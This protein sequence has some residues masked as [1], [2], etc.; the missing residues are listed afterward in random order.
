MPLC[1]AATLVAALGFACT[2]A[3]LGDNSAN[4]VL[5]S[6]AMHPV[7]VAAPANLHVHPARVGQWALYRLIDASGM[8]YEYVGITRGKCGVWFEDAWVAG[9]HRTTS[10][11]CYREMPDLDHG[12]ESWLALVRVAV[13][14]YDDELPRVVDLRAGVAPPS[15]L[16][17]QLHRF[18]GNFDGARWRH[19]DLP[20]DDVDVSAG[21]FA[22]AVRVAS[23]RNA[24]TMWFHPEV[25]ITGMV[26][27][28]ARDG[29]ELELAAFGEQ[30]A[31]SAI[32]DVPDSGDDYLTCTQAGIGALS[33]VACYDWRDY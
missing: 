10:K 19:D 24:A 7:H 30:G 23:T 8:G 16:P 32:A 27:S 5:A 4:I 20:R 22:R 14:Q 11:V 13:V 33:S 3:Y 26:M 17:A 15:E 31:T 25:P 29:T 12:S 1:I 21:S 6:R 28:R 9:G 18:Q 2:P